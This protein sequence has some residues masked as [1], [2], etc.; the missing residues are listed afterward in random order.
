MTAT[1]WLWAPGHMTSDTLIATST[2]DIGN[3]TRQS[4]M[5]TA[6]EWL[7]P[8]NESDRFDENTE[9]VTGTNGYGFG[10]GNPTI[11]WAL[12]GLTPLMVAYVV[13]T[14]FSGGARSYPATIAQPI[15]RATGTTVK[16]YQAIAYRTPFSEAD[17]VAGGLDQ[18][19]IEFRNAV[20][21][22][23]PTP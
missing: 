7:R 11:K 12:Q 21:I 2:Y 20:L 5:T 4:D 23:A 22:A 13:T 8:G 19:V 1:G 9:I 10:Y 18:W 16:Y 14:N 17:L 15:N 6:R 3:Y